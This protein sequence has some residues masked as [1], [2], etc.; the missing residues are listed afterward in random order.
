MQFT[1][2][3][4]VPAFYATMLRIDHTTFNLTWDSTKG[5]TVLVV[6]TPYGKSPLDQ[7]E[8]ICEKMS[9]ASLAEDN[10]T[11]V[12]PNIWVRLV[13]AAQKVRNK[14]CPIRGL[15]SSSTVFC[16]EMQGDACLVHAPQGPRN[17]S[18]DIP[19][20]M[21]FSVQRQTTMVKSGFLGLGAAREVD[22]GFY[23]LT[24]L[25]PCPPGYQ[26]GD[27]FFSMGGLRI[28]VTRAMLEQK[29]VYFKTPAP[30]MPETQNT[31]LQ[32]LQR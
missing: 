22:T 32:L 25:D 15:A 4:T 17:V 26:D 1:Y 8:A 7:M 29:V 5:Q 31:G 13:T 11:E 23:S 6:Q 27:I 19:A 14:G 12:M 9:A 21:N 16:C 10:Y 2:S 28:P 24:F 20:Q 30:P 18:V 3:P